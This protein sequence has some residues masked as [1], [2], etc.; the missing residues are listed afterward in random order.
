MRVRRVVTATM[1]AARRL[2]SSSAA[3]APPRYTASAFSLAP[4]RFGQPAGQQEAERLAAARLVV[5]GE[6]HEAPPCIQMQRRTAEAMLDAG[7]IGSQG[8]L[9]QANPLP[10]DPTSNHC[11]DIYPDNRGYTDIASPGYV[12]SVTDNGGSSGGGGGSDGGIGA[13]KH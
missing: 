4:A 13:M 2:S 12:D 5:F 6:I 11:L 8:T 1:A 7:D 3:P 10:P 9:Y